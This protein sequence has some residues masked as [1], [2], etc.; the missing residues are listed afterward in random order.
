M[1]PDRSFEPDLPPVPAPSP[2][3]QVTVEFMRSSGPGGQ[4]VNKVETAVR[5]RLDVTGSTALEAAVKERLIALA[6]RRATAAGEVLVVSR[7]HRTREENRRAALAKLAELIA[8][9][10]RAPRPRR[11]TKPGRAAKARRLKAKAHRA[12]AKQGRRRPDRED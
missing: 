1:S 9:A 3:D 4:N 2:L 10:S 5:V 7:K 8:L 6:G 11:A 12:D